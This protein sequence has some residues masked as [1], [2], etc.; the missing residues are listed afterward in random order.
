MAYNNYAPPGSYGRPPYGGFPPNM[1]PPPAMGAPQSSLNCMFA[2]A[3]YVSSGAAPGM[4]PP[5]GMSPAAT[6]L[7][8][9]PSSVAAPFAPPQNLPDIN[10]NAPV[11]RLGVSQSNSK[12]SPY[13]YDSR[14]PDNASGNRSR[15]GLGADQRLPRE[16]VQLV[17]PTLEEV[18]R[19]IFIGG[20]VEGV[21]DDAQLEDILGAGGQGPVK[22]RRWTRVT[23][24]DGK[25]CRFGF[26]EYEDAGALQLATEI[27]KDVEVPLREKGKLLKDEEGN[28]KKATLMVVVDQNSLE[29]IEKWSKP[30]A[31]ELQFRLDTAK[32]DL[33]RVLAQLSSK[34]SLTNGA[35]KNG[36]I[37]MEDGHKP[38]GA[39]VITIPV[40][41]EDELSDIPA[42]MRETV[43]AEIKSF[44]DRSIQRDI[45]RLRKEEELE[46][47]E[48]NRS[49]P[50]P[51]RLASPPPS[52][53]SGP[54]GVNGVPVGPR[55]RT[56]AGAPSG[57]KGYRGAQ[58]PKDYVDGVNFVNGK[59]EDDDDPA[60]DSELERRREEKKNAELEK[61]YLDQ[62]RRW[63]NVERRHIQALARADAEEEA[64][65]SARQQRRE[66]LAQKYR[67]FDDEEELRRPT[68]LFYRDRKAWIRARRDFKHAER[69]RDEKDRDDERKE[70]AREQRKMDGARGLADDFLAETGQELSRNATKPQPRAFTLNLGSL[71]ANNAARE[72]SEEPEEQQKKG[73]AKQQTMAEME[74]L[75]DDEED[76]TLG[77]GDRKKA[78][79]RAV[80]FKPLA[81]GEKMNDDERQAATRA[82]AASIPTS[83]TDLFGWPVKWAHLPDSVIREQ[84]RPY[85]Q[86]KIFESLGV[87]EDMLV[88]VIEGVVRRH[89]R[90]EEIVEELSDTLDEEAEGLA[91]KVW[92][93]V[94]FFS[95]SEAR[96]LVVRE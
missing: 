7:P 26:A 79:L 47:A 41:A 12:P 75:L 4:S 30:S 52:A 59:Q 45:E 6:P 23:D 81:A 38:D 42:E 11:I 71:G 51:S 68:E 72:E 8:G 10:F 44:R 17:P 70:R 18:S 93:M 15:Q 85:V 3:D 25:P 60:S 16:T 74:G 73:V 94:V 39:E 48:R 86:K 32:D 2:C 31:E 50:R 35:D 96:G 57:P 56:V 80:D 29:Y 92:R 37:V 82:L 88:E 5:P 90:P 22:L 43:A 61:V 33:N 19:T 54:G 69:S 24:A 76:N 28:V 9:R 53:P 55:D 14:A 21:P 77:S 20:L 95:E 78:L 66:S 46:A 62:E 63:L 1:G 87:Q 65:Q 84:L 36:D 89:G 91:R 34:D 40:S 64:E 49:A 13:G 27:F 83:L 67:E 58:M